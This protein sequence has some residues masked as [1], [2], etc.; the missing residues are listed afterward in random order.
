M[1]VR[2]R[3]INMAAFA[4]M[5]TSRTNR[6]P[7]NSPGYA[8]KLFWVLVVACLFG[9][10]AALPYV[11]A[12]FPSMVARGPLPMPLPIL[13]TAQ[14]MQSTI[15]FGGIVALGIL[16]SR[17]AGIEA[18]ILHGWL[19]R[20]GAA[21]PAGWLRTPLWWGL[22]IGV[23]VFFLYFLVFLP[24]IPEWPLQEEAALPIWKR[25]LMCFYGA[26]NIELLMRFFLLSLFVWLSKKVTGNAS[27]QASPGIFWTANLIVALIYAA[28]HIPA[29]KSLMPLTPIVLT[30][31]LLPTGLVALAFGYLTWKRGIEA[32]M[33]AHFSSDF[34]AR[35][36]GPMI[37][38]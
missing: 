16:L 30:A 24:F 18:P 5:E 37:L 23:L 3:S 17:K 14:L 31:V 25:F 22:A 9:F 34:V 33:L 36:I 13:V 11:Y 8:W 38:H 2:Y 28:A 32:A 4:S 26:I 21:Y 35:V 27:P 6:Y 29:A 19:Y 10:G 7:V 20:T 15:V 1:S 12:L